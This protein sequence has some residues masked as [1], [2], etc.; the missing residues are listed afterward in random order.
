MSFSGGFTTQ[1]IPYITGSDGQLLTWSD[2]VQAWIPADPI[3]TGLTAVSTDNGIVGDGTPSNPVSLDTSITVQNLT[4]TNTAS[5][6]HIDTLEMQSLI[7]GD[8]YIT[9]LSGANNHTTADGAGILWGS[10]SNDPTTGDQGSIAYVLYRSGSD[11]IEVFP[12]ATVSGSLDV[13]GVI[14]GD[15]SGLTNL[16]TSFDH[17]LYVSKD[18]NDS[19]RGSFTDALATI[20]GAL[21][22]AKSNFPTGESVLVEV[23]PGTYSEDLTL[24][25]YGVY[26]KS[27]AAKY[28]QKAV[29][30]TGKTLISAVGTVRSSHIVGIE[31]IF[32]NYSSTTTPTVDISGS[33]QTTVYLKDCYLAANGSN[34]LRVRGITAANGKVVL[35]KSYFLSQK[36]TADNIRIEGGY[37]RADTIEV[38]YPNSVSAGTGSGIY[39]AGNATLVVDRL[40][41]EM[42]NV[43]TGSSIIA[44]APTYVSNASLSSSLTAPSGAVYIGT[45][46]TAL[47]YNTILQNNFTV[48]GATPSYTVFSDLVSPVSM[49]T[50]VGTTPIGMN[51]RFGAINATTVT[52]SVGFSGTL[53][54]TAS[55]ALDAGKLGGIAT[56][57]YARKDLSNTF[58]ADQVFDI[59]SDVICSNFLEY[60]E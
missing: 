42:P 2:A 48:R 8:K 29:T 22:Y 5:I 49:P 23:G 51:A 53:Y 50:F 6:A 31:G 43:V 35:D 18:G 52:A 36:G 60:I 30:V 54:G 34:T 59:L 58:S 47:L 13:A 33:I 1:G 40:L 25:R 56:S 41:V 24:D 17:T 26:I 45:N 15:G 55:Y 28:E 27:N 57:S 10:G 3:D 4:V 37:V 44:N 9:I 19:N 14:S 21:A 38:S 32:F 12:S 39:V 7:V 11:S 46:N 16:P 20:S